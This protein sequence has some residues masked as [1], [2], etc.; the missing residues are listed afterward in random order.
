[1][2]T[3][4]PPVEYVPDE[5]TLLRFG[6]V[7]RNAHRIHYDTAFARSEGLDGPV[8]MA[9]LHGC[10]F[11]RAAAAYAGETGEVLSVGWQNRA[12]AYA[13]DRLVVSGVVESVDEETGHITLAL[14]EH[15]FPDG[16]GPGTLCC[17]GHAV[18][19]VQSSDA[20]S[21]K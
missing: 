20:R 1:M 4:V 16:E 19:A 9:Q 6:S 8:V 2:R 18:V 12:P 3:E 21:S 13:G 17:R 14:E 5:I 11:H 15:R 7:T 10:L